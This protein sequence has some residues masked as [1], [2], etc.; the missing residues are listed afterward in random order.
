MPDWFPPPPFVRP[1]VLLILLPVGWAWRRFG[2]TGDRRTDGLRLA[3]A[4]LL[5]AAAAGPVWDR[6]GRGLDVILVLDRSRSMAGESAAGGRSAVDLRELVAGV[7]AARGDGDRVGVVTFGGVAAV[8]RAPA[9]AAQLAEFARPVD[10][11]G[12]DLDAALTLAL[13]LVDPRRPARVVVLSDGEGNGPDPRPAA[14]R[15]RAAGVPVDVRPVPAPRLGDAAVTAV[16]VPSSAAPGEPLAVGVTVFSPE[17]ATGT[18]SLSRTAPGGEPVRVGERRIELPAGRSRVR[19][20]DSAPASGFHVYSA[21]LRVPG[22]ARGGNDVGEAGLRVDAPHRV[23]VLRG[24]GEVSRQSAARLAGALAGTG[25]PA[26]VRDAADFPLTQNALDGYGAVVLADVPAATLGRRK[27]ARLAQFVVD[28]AGGLLTTGGRDSYAAGGYAESPLEPLLPVDLSP[29]DD[30]RR[31]RTAIVVALDRSGSMAVPAGGGKTK[32]DLANDGAAAVVMVLNPGDRAAVL[33]VDTGSTA[34]L[35]LTEIGTPA[36]QSPARA[37]ETARTVRSGGGGIYVDAA[38][39]AAA[40]ELAAAEDFAAKHVIVFADAADAES[41]TD[42][43]GPLARLRALGATVSVIGLGTRFDPDAWLLEEVAEAGGGTVRFTADPQELPRLFAQDA[44]SVTRDTFVTTDDPAGVPASFAPG[45]ALVGEATGGRFPGVG[46]YNL[47]GDADGASVA[48]R[49]DD[50]YAAPLA[51]A[52]YRGAGRAAALTFPLAGEHAGPA[53]AWDG[54]PGFLATHGRWLLGGGDAGGAYV[55]AEVRGRVAEVRVELDPA[56]AGDGA[57]GEEEVPEL[58]VVPPAD[59]PDGLGAAADAAPFSA[60][61]RWDGPGAL[62]ASFPL[63]RVGTYRT[64]LRWPGGRT[65]RGP[66]VSLPYSPEFLPRAGLPPGA[67]VLAELAAVSGGTTRTDLTTVFADPPPRPAPA[68]AWGWFAAAALLCLLAEIA[69]RRWGWALPWRTDRELVAAPRTRD[70][71]PDRAPPPA[72]PPPPPV[73][74]GPTRPAP[75]AG[76]IFG[77][78]KARA[79]RRR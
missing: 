38:L 35:P 13:D 43:R 37:A 23:L 67:A 46:G 24:G 44:L 76:D 15:A 58:F 47:C 34:V 61:L 62:S 56:A 50:E 32:M 9:E 5:V 40:D 36:G 2:R 11:D 30:A 59:D 71:R 49:T 14:R 39:A 77:A 20:R 3:V 54:L 33:A 12:T 17:P 45:A 18:V 48:V 69:G 55:N 21:A 1:A 63:G 53:G 6:G 65:A 51:A 78:A 7:E 66:A 27:L 16:S 73:P 72:A 68:A 19:F 57:G 75:T 26:D 22:D 74:T 79:G 60:D 31:D 42:Y 64:L 25:L 41:P 70:R 10:P 4:A 29:R 28:L 8:E 52:W